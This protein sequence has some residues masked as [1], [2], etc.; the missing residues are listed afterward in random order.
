MLIG[1][2]PFVHASTTEALDPT[3]EKKIKKLF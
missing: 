1:P 2:Q 3:L